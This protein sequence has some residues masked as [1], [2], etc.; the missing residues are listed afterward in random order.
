MTYTKLCNKF[1][2]A[3]SLYCGFP[4]A[5]D[6]NLKAQS[7]GPSGISSSI[8][9]PGSSVIATASIPSA[10]SSSLPELDEQRNVALAVEVAQPI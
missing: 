8:V 1:I 3:A 4:E 9:I 5:G 6:S 2:I 7:L 10:S